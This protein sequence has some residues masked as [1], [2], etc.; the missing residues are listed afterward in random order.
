MKEGE[1][2]NNELLIITA[3]I[4]EECLSESLDILEKSNPAPK[5]NSTSRRK[6]KRP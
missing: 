1:I 5:K 6:T 3:D 2:L 4:I